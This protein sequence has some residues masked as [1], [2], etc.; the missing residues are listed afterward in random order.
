[1][2]TYPIFLFSL[3]RLKVLAIS[4][5]LPL[6]V[7]LANPLLLQMEAKI[8]NN[9]WQKRITSCAT[10]YTSVCLLFDLPAWPVSYST[11]SNYLCYKVEQLDGSA[12][13]VDNWLSALRCYARLQ[14]LGWLIEKDAYQV[15]LLL[16]QLKYE[17][18]NPSKFRRPATLDVIAHMR[19][20]LGPDNV[21]VQDLRWCPLAETVGVNLFRSKTHRVGPS[22]EVLLPKCGSNGGYQQLIAWMDRWQFWEHTDWF[23]FPIVSRQGHPNFRLPYSINSW[24]AMLQNVTLSS[25]LQGYSGHSF[26]AGGATDLFACGVSI[27]T[28]QKYGRWKSM[29]VL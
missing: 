24:R 22:F 3:G 26:R 25:G 10:N 13:S 6:T 8:Q 9:G 12:K 4:E 14:D 15:K 16:A 27:Q 17:D 18:T 19:L 2:I 23:V 28:V 20:F 7:R 29:A 21:V 5:T 1:V 11:I